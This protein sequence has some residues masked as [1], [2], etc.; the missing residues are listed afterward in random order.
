[1]EDPL[2]SLRITGD[3]YIT[4][5]QNHT[6]NQNFS[7]MLRDVATNDTVCVSL[8]SCRHLQKRMCI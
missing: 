5:A 8:C 1:M 4:T 2:A 6:Y 3:M 7:G